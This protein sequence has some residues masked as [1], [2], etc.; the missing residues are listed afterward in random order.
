[1]HP[2]RWVLVFLPSSVRTCLP[3]IKRH[4]LALAQPRIHSL[5]ISRL[6]YAIGDVHGR[7]DLL[8]SML[9]FIA[10]DAERRGQEPRVI[11]L[12]DIVDR[13][14]DSRGAMELV[15]RTLKRW[16]S[17]RL[18]LGNHDDYFLHI[19]TEDVPDERIL[20]L[21]LRN[22]GRATL[23]SYD[24]LGDFDD[25]RMTVRIDFADHLDLLRSA[26]LIDTDGS[27]A[28]VHAGIDSGKPVDAQNRKDCLTIRKGFLDYPG[29]LS[30]TVVHGH[31]ITDSKLPEV[32]GSRIALDTGAY[33]TG[34]LTALIIDPAAD[35]LEFA[36]TAQ[37]N[38]RISVQECPHL[39]GLE[40]ILDS[41]P[42]K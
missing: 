15:A 9:A 27:F 31:S 13:G 21:W 37:S 3:P 28:F 32:V 14:P 7:S 25:A 34:R 30:H 33:A 11:F 22:G 41:S 4:R 38:G 8:R 26:S 10:S 18:L 36:C 17:S 1:M 6:T 12:G 16:P 5:P 20:A 19:V 23:E 24:P 42:G 35:G 29:P 2:A 40:T 39:Q